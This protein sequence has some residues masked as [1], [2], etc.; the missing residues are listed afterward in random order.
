MTWPYPSH[1]PTWRQ[2][3]IQFRVWLLFVADFQ[4]CMCA[5][6][7]VTK[8]VPRMW[9]MNL[10]LERPSDIQCVIIFEIDIVI[11]VIWQRYAWNLLKISCRWLVTWIPF[12]AIEL[13][14]NWIFYFTYLFVI[15]NIVI[16]KSTLPY[17]D[18]A[19]LYD[20]FRVWDCILCSQLFISLSALFVFQDELIDC[21]G[22]RCL[23]WHSWTFC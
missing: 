5:G 19:Y 1:I 22:P 7:G 23:T 15:I 20:L 2:N 14:N 16:W 11:H 9:N 17:I 12:I 18:L 21:L 10:E 3:C 4:A 13:R 8:F 6:A